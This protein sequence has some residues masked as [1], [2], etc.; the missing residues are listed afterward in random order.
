MANDIG[1]A[2]YLSSN[3]AAQLFDEMK[4][5]PQ[6][7]GKGKGKGKKKGAAAAAASGGGLRETTRK[8]FKLDAIPDA[9]TGEDFV[10]AVAEKMS[11]DDLERAGTR[12]LIDFRSGALGAFC[13]EPAPRKGDDYAGGLREMGKAKRVV[14]DAPTEVRLGYGYYDANDEV[15]LGVDAEDDLNR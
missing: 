1:E 2:S 15:E 12:V 10:V 14:M 5:L 8:R 3:V 9:M 4:T 7:L 13:L 6:W 11:S